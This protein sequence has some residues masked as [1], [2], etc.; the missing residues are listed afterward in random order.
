MKIVTGS[1][2][3]KHITAN[4]DGALHEAIFGTGCYVLGVGEAFPCTIVS[5]TEL[6]IGP[7]E[8]LMYGRHFRT[9]PGSVDTL[10]IQ[11]GATGY[12]RNDIIAAYYKN[13]GGYESIKLVALT[14]ASATGAAT[15]PDF[16]QDDISAGASE[17]YFPLYRVRLNGL[18]IEG[19]DTL[20]TLVDNTLSGLNMSWDGLTG[21]PSAFTPASHAHGKIT[22]AG[23][24]SG[25]TQPMLII[26]D[27]EG[28]II[29]SRTFSGDLTIH[30][31]ITATKVVGAVYA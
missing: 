13:V 6:Q 3:Q 19:I 31:T 17:S 4:D 28:N 5:N 25:V 15:D 30:G 29:A 1:T 22:N 11:A 23:K 2:G 12:N 8:G 7:G 18:S 24:I 14:G 21:K 10:A 16:P 27:A 20:Y 9:P 26:T